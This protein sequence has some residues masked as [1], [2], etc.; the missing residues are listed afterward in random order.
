MTLAE[1]ILDTGRLHDSEQARG[2]T[3]DERADTGRSGA[4]YEMLTGRRA[5]DGELPATDDAL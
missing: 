3:V 1:R 5:F 2:K 4:L